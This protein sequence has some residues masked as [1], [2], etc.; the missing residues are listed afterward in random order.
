MANS[1]PLVESVSHARQSPLW[2]AEV[3]LAQPGRP[4]LTSDLAVD[5]AIVG[6][7]FSGLWSAYSL[8]RLDPSLDIAI[9]EAGFVGFGASGRNGGWCSSLFPASWSKL[10]SRSSD[11]AAMTMARLVRE[12]VDVVGSFAAEHQIAIDWQ[13]GG[14]LLVAHDQL[15]MQRAREH[16]ESERRWGNDAMRLLSGEELQEVCHTRGLGATFDPSC[17]VIQPAKLVAG[18]ARIVE[19]MGVRIFEKSRVNE[20]LPKQGST[21]TAVV[22]GLAVRAPVILRATEAY[23]SL[24]PKAKREIV[25]VYSLMIATEPL[26]KEVWQNIGLTDRTTF[27]DYGNLVIYGQ[28]TADDRIAFGG[29]GAP[30]HFGSSISAKH[31]QDLTVH[32]SLATTLGQWFPDVM[33]SRVE[34]RWGGPVGIPRDWSAAVR[35]DQQTGLGSVGGYV[36]DGVGTSNLA[37]RTFA[38]LVVGNNSELT[39]MPWVNQPLHKWEVE[40]FRWLGVNAAITAVQAAD[41]FESRT[42]RDAPWAPVL[43]KLT[44]D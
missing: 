8:K 16:V 41:W 39:A 40:P 3:D 19:N 1:T 43:S 34:Y 2:W 26:S 31:D 7:G 20:L 27:A 9:L 13:K 21:A 35:Y 42:G 28:R 33:K 37:G 32:R 6:G 4:S 25:P 44:G 12:A 18:L 11:L 17:A 10:A 22:G 14:T 23:S 24:L 36:G 15:Q 30:Y 5:V 38:D 29:R